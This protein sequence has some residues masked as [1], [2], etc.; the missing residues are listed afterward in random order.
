MNN[1][2]C[3]RT[4]RFSVNVR[5]IKKSVGGK[6]NRWVSWFGYRKQ[7]SFMSYKWR[8]TKPTTKP[9]RYTSKSI[10]VGLLVLMQF[11]NEGTYSVE[12]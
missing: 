10:Y 5:V 8:T 4:K 9:I 6:K 2:L 11:M 7:T 1:D 12:I 3:F